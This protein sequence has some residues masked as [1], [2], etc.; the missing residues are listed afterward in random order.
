MSIPLLLGACVAS[1]RCPP[2]DSAARNELRTSLHPLVR[3]SQCPGPPT[4]AAFQ[5]AAGEISR[6]KAAL[7]DRVARSPLAEDLA[8][9]KREDEEANRHL[10]AA[11]CALPFWDRPEDPENVA[12]Y[13]A[14]LDAERRELEA[15]EKSFAQAI[16]GCPAG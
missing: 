8:R 1:P 4:P 11:E 16:A 13:P 7:I 5:L 3:I 14:L 9:V 2:P 6:R 12:A 15:A 10:T